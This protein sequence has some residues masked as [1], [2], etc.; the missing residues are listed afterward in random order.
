L[1]RDLVVSDEVRSHKLVLS[2][3]SFHFF[4]VVEA[5]FAAQEI[6]KLCV[7]EAA[8][9]RFDFFSTCGVIGLEPQTTPQQKV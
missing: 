4:R 1:E 3:F 8:D 6:D 2:E 7:R 5:H 9:A